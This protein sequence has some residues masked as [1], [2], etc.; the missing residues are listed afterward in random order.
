MKLSIY[1]PEKSLLVKKSIEEALV[2]S[3]K[4]EL[5]ILPGHASLVSLL[6]AGVLKYKSVGAS[7]WEKV[8]IGWG[9]LEIS[10][11]EIKV[12]AESAETKETLNRIQVEKELQELESQLLKW[13]L[14]PSKREELEKQKLWLQGEKDL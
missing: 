7:Q 12:L 1:T 2:P 6:Q 4:G 3:V 10:K 5:G 11:E 9:Y 13:D 8:A 14:D